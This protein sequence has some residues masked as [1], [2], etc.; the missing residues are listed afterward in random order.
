MEK[1]KEG[2]ASSVKDQRGKDLLSPEMSQ[3]PTSCHVCRRFQNTEKEKA[4]YLAAIE[5][6]TNAAAE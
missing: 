4:K 2:G 3:K 6:A 1:K 5:K